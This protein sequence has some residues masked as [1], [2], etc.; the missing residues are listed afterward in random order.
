MTF[1]A[2]A[3]E[4]PLASPVVTELAF[5][6][7]LESTAVAEFLDE[8]SIALWELLIDKALDRSKAVASATEAEVPFTAVIEVSPPLAVEVAVTVEEPDERDV[9]VGP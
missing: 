5:A 3:P 1:S 7:V 9:A 8:A 6:P 2:F 4:T